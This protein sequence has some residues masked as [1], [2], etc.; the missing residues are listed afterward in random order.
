M[1]G[2]N[3]RRQHGGRKLRQDTV[4]LGHNFVHISADDH[5][6]GVRKECFNGFNRLPETQTSPERVCPWQEQE[7]RRDRQ[8]PV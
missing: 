2:D 3:F 8:Y 1:A 5:H 4:F 6:V 7:N